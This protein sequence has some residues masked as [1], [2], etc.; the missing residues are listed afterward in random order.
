MKEKKLFKFF[1]IYLPIVMLILGIGYANVSNDLIASGNIAMKYQDDIAIIS[2]SPST[3]IEN[4]NKTI[5]TTNL[6][7]ENSSD[8]K[9][10]SI[11]IKNLGNSKQIFDGI[12]YDKTHNELYSNLNI[13]PSISGITKDTIINSK[14]HEDDSITFDL[15]FAYDDTENITDNTLNGTINLH[16]TSLRKITYLNCSNSDGEGSEY[17][18]SKPFVDINGVTSY[19]TVTLANPPSNIMI[20]N[21]SNDSLTQGVDYTYNNSMGIITFINNI[22]SDIIISPVFS[23]TYVLDGGVQAQNQVTSILPSEIVR[24]L[25]PTKDGY[26]FVGWYNNPEFTGDK[27]TELSN[28]SSNIILYANWSLYDYYKSSLTLGTKDDVDNTGIMLYSQENVNKNVRIMFTVDDYNDNYEDVA[29]IDSKNG[30]TILSSMNEAGSPWPG[31]VFRIVANK[32]I[33]CFS[34][35]INDS[36]VKSYTGYY[37]LSKGTKVEIVREDGG[38][39]IKINS[40]VY[41]KIFTYSNS[42]DTFNVPITIGGNINEK[43]QYDRFFDGSL[44]NVVVDFYEGNIVNEAINLYTETK[45]DK[46]YKLTG[47]IKFDGNNYIDT[48]LNLFSETNI[49]KDFD[50]SFTLES[51]DSPA[52]K[53]TLVNAKDESQTDVWPGFAYRYDS[54][55]MSITAR[56]PGETFANYPDSNLTPKKVKI[57]RRDGI[58]YYSIAGSEETELIST[59]SSSLTN[60]INSNLTFGAS[61]DSSGNPFRFFKGLVSDI[62][63]NI[64]D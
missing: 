64:Y 28:V 23:I 32:G 30:P 38:I 6:E 21:H 9:N 61:I 43:G 15:S 7:L 57:S 3:Y 37:N 27:I 55:K 33:P 62:S 14:G 47:T 59:P 11:T 16:F 19:D 40:N 60:P 54:G 48:G 45:T 41:T 5:F 4:Y 2:I 20:T 34:I 31:F 50:I 24:L 17:V 26:N 29:N 12:I 35:K 44:S 53:A 13:V 51:T 1:I 42:I 46:L 25:K 36:H 52:Q 39:Y 22:N 10:M 56:W 8:S 63:V 58:I 49:N 18:R